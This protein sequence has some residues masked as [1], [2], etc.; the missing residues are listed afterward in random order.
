MTI[1]STLFK[2]HWMTFI[3]GILL[4]LTFPLLA[5]PINVVQEAVQ[6]HTGKTVRWEQDQAA[7]AQTEQDVRN[8]LH[9][10]L[11]I[12]AAVQIAL[13]NNRS[14]QATFEEIGLSAAELKDA[15]TIP[16]PSF[17]LSIKFPDKAPSGTDLEFGTAIDFLRLL[18]LPLRK[19]VA[20]EQLE[21]TTLRVADETLEL[22]AQVKSAFYS[23]QASQQLLGRLKLI[24]EANS[25]ALELAQRQHEAGNIADL[26]LAQQLTAYSRS[27]VEVAQT[28]AEIR[29]QR[30]KLNRLLGLW[31]SETNW[32]LTG[33]LPDVPGSDLSVSGLERLAISQ[34]LDLQAQYL[35]VTSLVRALGLTKNF[36]FIG[37][38]NFGVD[39][40]RGSNSQ[41]ITGPTFVLELPIFNQGQAAIS[42][43]E[44][45]LRRQ[46]RK[47]EALA[48]DVRS[49]VREL[50]DQLSSQRELAR[51][52]R[53]ELL[54][55][56]RQILSQILL[57][58]NA[59]QVSP[60]ELFTAKT[61]EAQIER[62]YIGAVRDYWIARA[63]LER[64]VGGSL[65]PLITGVS[66]KITAPQSPGTP[67][68]SVSN[69]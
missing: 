6:S 28:G 10:P 67:A 30:E 32:E 53:D 27:R 19:R 38:L 25:V 15:G 52:Y 57:N 17:N 49:R 22:V 66:R 7:M 63:K 59:M 51:F 54:P 64:A 56:Q 35:G 69:P 29:Q 61:E 45:A 2:R 9:E 4:F 36:R 8:L 37:A 3:T 5:K 11:T 31:G 41:T 23:V 55:N 46:Q 39:S 48:I 26:A 13:L 21:A 62:E 65:R 34:R 1:I 33:S 20:K 42:R 16:N 47:F 58:Y 24:S 68:R 14:L 40:E 12:N 44:A 18:M 50:R 43:S 60:L